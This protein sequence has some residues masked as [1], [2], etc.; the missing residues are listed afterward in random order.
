MMA[1]LKAAQKVPVGRSEPN[2]KY[3]NTLAE[4]HQHGRSQCTSPGTHGQDRVG[5]AVPSLLDMYFSVSLA[6]HAKFFHQLIF[7]PHLSR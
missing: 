5:P 2:P 6:S 3:E 4:A 7:V 1:A